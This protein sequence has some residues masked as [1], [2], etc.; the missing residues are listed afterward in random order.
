M[1]DWQLDV[2]KSA[3][4]GYRFQKNTTIVF[5][6]ENWIYWKLN[7]RLIYSIVY[8]RTTS[9]WNLRRSEIP[10]KTPPSSHWRNMSFAKW[11]STK[12]TPFHRITRKAGS[13]GAYTRTERSLSHPFNTKNWN[14]SWISAGAVYTLQVRLMPPTILTFGTNFNE[15]LLGHWIYRRP[16]DKAVPWN[17]LLEHPEIDYNFRGE[18]RRL[19]KMFGKSRGQ[20]ALEV[21]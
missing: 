8:H 5:R 10:G 14:H 13:L 2:R 6:W 4:K 18:L 9:S 16:A 21:W 7:D 15:I 17:T 19:V 11:L 12:S 20:L 1:S 3:R